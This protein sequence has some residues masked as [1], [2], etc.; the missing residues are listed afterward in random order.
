VLLV[1]LVVVAAVAAAVA[2]VTVA[3]VDELVF[4]SRPH[5]VLSSSTNN[6]HQ[7]INRIVCSSLAS[8]HPVVNSVI[9]D[10]EK[11]MTILQKKDEKGFMF[12]G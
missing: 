4:H 5:A 3:V 2:A 9:Q 8:F 11:E 12:T 1:S 7:K 10:F 6:H